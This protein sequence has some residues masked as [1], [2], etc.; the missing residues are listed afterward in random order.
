[1]GKGIDDVFNFGCFGIL[2]DILPDG[3][4]DR[5]DACMDKRSTIFVVFLFGFLQV[6]SNFFLHACRKGS[7]IIKVQGPIQLAH[8]HLGFVKRVI[9]QV[10]IPLHHSDIKSGEGCGGEQVGIFYAMF[11]QIS[12]D[13][14]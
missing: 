5:N 9:V 6:I 13:T 10:G 7:I 8:P 4:L 2:F 3:G 14:A 11:F 12:P 1:M